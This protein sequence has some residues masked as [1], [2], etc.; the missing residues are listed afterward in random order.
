MTVGCPLALMA[1]AYAAYTLRGSALAA[2][3]DALLHLR[4]GG[5]EGERLV[6]RPL[7][8]VE[9]KPLRRPLPDAGQAGELGDEVLDGGAE[10]VPG[11]CPPNRSGPGR[12]R[13]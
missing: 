11:F 9:R 7:E 2:E 8:D 12:R 6:G 10:H 13:S 3:P 4:E 5:G 1:A